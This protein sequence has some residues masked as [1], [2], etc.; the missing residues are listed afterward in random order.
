[1]HHLLWKIGLLTTAL[2][3]GYGQLT[4]LEATLRTPLNTLFS[5]AF[6]PMAAFCFGAIILLNRDKLYLAAL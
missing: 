4:L 2:T 3:L 6:V 5:W 1:M